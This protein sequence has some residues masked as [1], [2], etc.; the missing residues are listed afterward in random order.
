MRL[1]AGLIALLLPGLAFAQAVV[2]SPR[3]DKVAL[4]VYRDPNG[5][6]GINLGWLNGFAMVSETRRVTL[7]AG[8]VDLRFEGVTQ[9]IL[10]QSAI[11]TG[12][13]DALVEKNR[14]AMLLSPGTL[15]DAMLGQRVHLRRTSKATGEVAEQEAVIRASGNGII[16]QTEAGFEALRCTGL[17]ETLLPERI[18]ETL[19][20]RPTL[21]TR[22]R[23]SRPVEAEVTLT[24]LSSNFDWRAHYVATVAPDGK[25]MDLF[26]WLTL[27]N[28]DSTA[29]ADADT[30]A[31]A[32]RL[33]RADTR[34][35]PPESRPIFLNCWPAARTHQIPLE[36]FDRGGPPPPPPP[37]PMMSPS[38]VTTID[39][40]EIMVTGSRI[41]R[42]KPAEREDLGDLKLYRIP[43]PVTVAARSQ[44]QVALLDRPGAKFHMVHRFT[45][46]LAHEQVR[47]LP[48]SRVLIAEN[49]K[50][51]GLGLPLPAG[52]FTLY[53]DR[54][55]EAFLLGEGRM[56]DRAEGEKVE[57]AL[58]GAPGVLVT[59]RQ[60]EPEGKIWRSATIE[61]SNDGARPAP[62]EVLFGAGTTLS[63][64]SERI[65]R[66]DGQPLWAVTVP[67]NGTRS[68][69]YRWKA[70][71]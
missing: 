24:Y 33:N 34:V 22:L 48:V 28:G 17:G 9:G 45:T 27:A 12:L 63:D 46:Y 30:Y 52:S 64:P 43:I 57:V 31:V 50:A 32:G 14:D 18:P 51:D 19:S 3:P 21:S 25:T 2:T 37:P 38:P 71:D 58:D 35:P 42:A 7:P 5:T 8:D 40:Q 68:L 54:Q 61:V 23:L 26:A 20:A 15:I 49:R 1:L 69:R 66:R 65:A 29:L 6:G 47:P 62:V 53:T 59:Q 11:V 4:T 44:K 56:T 70:E 41:A 60:D 55:G 16:I 39:A 36:D 67:A 13:G 10:P